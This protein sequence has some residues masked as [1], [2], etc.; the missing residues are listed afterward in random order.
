MKAN[1]RWVFRQDQPT[2]ARL[3]SRLVKHRRNCKSVIRFK[4][5]HKIQ[6]TIQKD[7]EGEEQ[8]QAADRLRMRVQRWGRTW[9][10]GLQFKRRHFGRWG[11]EGSDSKQLEARSPV[12]LLQQY[13][14]RWNC[15]VHWWRQK[16]MAHK[17]WR[18]KKISPTQSV[19]KRK[20]KKG[21]RKKEKHRQLRL[22]LLRRNRTTKSLKSK[23]KSSRSDW[24][25]QLPVLIV[26][27]KCPTWILC[28]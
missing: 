20:R 7:R 9:N 23:S 28:L 15:Q 14:R 24:S 18:M 2:F 13:E 12:R 16:K 11:G 4:P 21:K 3:P 6:D 19:Q 5:K 25:S 8:L 22:L 26:K 10:L 1:G 27:S 17:T